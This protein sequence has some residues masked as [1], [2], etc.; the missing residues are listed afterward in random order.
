VHFYSA[1]PWSKII[2]R[3]CGIRVRVSGLGNLDTDL[4]RIYMTN[5]Q[6]FFDI[7]ALLACLPV[8]FKFILKQELMNL[9]VFGP[10]T[11]RAGY[12]GIERDDPRKAVKSMNLAAERIKNGAS[13]LI[14]PEGT[15]SPDGRLGQFKKGGFSLAIKSGCDIVP[16]AISDSYRIAPK[17]SLR[18]KKG[19]FSLSIGKPISLAGYTKRKTPQLMDQVREAML[20]QM[21]KSG[22]TFGVRANT[23]FK[24]VGMILLITSLLLVM[25]GSSSGYLMPVD[26]LIDKMRARFSSFKT[27]IIDQSTHVLDPQDRE[28][29]MVFQEKTWIKSPGYCRSEITGRP[30]SLDKDGAPAPPPPGEP[31]QREG[32]VAYEV[33]E[34][35]GNSDTAFRRLLMANNRDTIMTFLAQMGVNLE[36]VGLTRLDGIVAYCVGDKGPESPKLL[37]NKESFLPLLFSYVPLRS[38]TQE[39]VVVRFDKYKQV[40][41]GWYPYEIGYSVETGRAERYFVL[42]IVVNPPIEASFFR[43][44]TEKTGIPQKP[45]NDRD[46]QQ[47]ERLKEVIR[48]LKEKYGN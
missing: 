6:S 17:G 22:S 28:T 34:A 30:E 11:R 5:H 1:V 13:V 18:I 16:V 40:D 37:I 43:I 2:L 39:L 19:S 41:S 38:S 14:F 48:V 42:N 15:R 23:N 10:A 47:E 29:T 46:G 8:N 21:E 35:Q 9:P 27:L 4:P 20:K 33:K 31:A 7:F 44:T 12:I 3:V 36:S 24:K 32:Q 26:Q 25:P 45:E